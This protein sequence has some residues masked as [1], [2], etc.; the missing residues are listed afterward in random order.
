MHLQDPTPLRSMQI[1]LDPH[2]LGLQGWIGSLYEGTKKVTKVLRIIDKWTTN[3]PRFTE[4]V[5]S[6]KLCKCKRI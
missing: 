2:G 3:K 5:A 4:K 1:E 6:D